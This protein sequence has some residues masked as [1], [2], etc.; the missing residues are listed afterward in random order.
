MHLVRSMLAGDEKK[1]R[2]AGEGERVWVRAAVF[3]WMTGEGL[4]EARGE[5][6]PD[7]WGI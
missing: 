5:G 6:L 2:R 1:K 3:S 4:T 7:R